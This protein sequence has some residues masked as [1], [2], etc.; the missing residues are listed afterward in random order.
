[1]TMAL[2][3]LSHRPVQDMD[4]P[5]ICSFPQSEEELFFMFPRASYPL[6][7]EQLSKA[8]SV[9]FDS[10][11][12]ECGGEI[13]GFANFHEVHLGENCSIGNV[14][15]R[16][17]MRGKGVGRYLI[18]TMISIAAE[19]YHVKTVKLA[20]FNHN[21][22]GLLLYNRLGFK[23]VFMEER[24]DKQEK[25]VVSIHMDYPVER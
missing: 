3:P 10:T 8:I 5:M 18:T 2:F 13:A 19:K 15:I 7:V 1:M 12:I 16:P 11:V 4:I 23:P 14:I 25:I 6:T 9:R 24:V 21:I 22:N 17:D 20:C